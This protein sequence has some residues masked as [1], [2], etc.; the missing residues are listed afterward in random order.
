MSALILMGL[1]VVETVV[2]CVSYAQTAKG[3]ATEHV[4]TPM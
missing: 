4:E 2:F 3:T 1:W